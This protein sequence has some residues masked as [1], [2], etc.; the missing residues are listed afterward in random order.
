MGFLSLEIIIRG[1]TMKT[2]LLAAIA[3]LFPLPGHAEGDPEAGESAF[4][5]C[6]SC[7]SI[8]NGDETIVRGGRTG[9][10]L[11]GIFGRTAGTYEDFRYSDGMVE[12]GENGLVWDEDTLLPYIEAPTDFLRDQLG[13]TSLRSKMTPQRLRDSG[14]DL[15][16]YLAQFGAADP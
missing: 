2:T 16:A 3:M 5:R 8:S 4:R 12:A 9:P 11:Y 14:P 6:K 10:N 1:L 7:H 13:D 15:L